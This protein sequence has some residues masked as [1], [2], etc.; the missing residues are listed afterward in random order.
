M[1]PPRL[2]VLSRRELEERTDWPVPA[3]VICIAYPK[4]RLHRVPRHDNIYDVTHH[5]FSDCLEDGTWCF[6]ANKAGRTAV[7]M[8]NMTGDRIRRFAAAWESALGPEMPREYVAACYGGV[9]RSRGVL[10]GLV[11]A[12]ILKPDPQNWAA[13]NDGRQN[14]HVVEMVRG[15]RG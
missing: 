1:T 8:S 6:P 7:P 11:E 5:R 4:G 12:G 13:V 3:V 15:P 10:V 9:S 2:T 14:P